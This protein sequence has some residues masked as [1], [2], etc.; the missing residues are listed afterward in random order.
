MLRSNP[1][2]LEV[3]AAGV[4]KEQ[5]MEALLAYYGIS[6]DRTV[7][8]GDGEVDIGM[9]RQAGLGIAMGN[10]SAAVRNAADCVTA[11]ND[12]E[13]VYLALKR[14]RFAARSE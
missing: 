12:E 2:Y 1:N 11:T 8:I 13:G 7:A 5:A 14:L 6:M 3:L 4:C 9:I 10:A